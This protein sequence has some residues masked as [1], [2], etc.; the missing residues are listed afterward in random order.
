M[1]MIKTKNLNIGY[2]E[3][4]IVEELNIEIPKGRITALVGGNG[5][6]KSTI[7]KTIARIL[8]PQKGRVY[9]DGESIHEKS[10]KDVALKLAILPQNP[11][12]PE[13]LTVAELVSYGRFP[14]QKKFGTLGA[15]DYDIIQWALDVTGMT[16]FAERPLN[17]LSGG[18]RQK[19][20]IAMA[21]AQGTDVILL[22]EPTT[23]LD[24]SHQFEVLKLLRKLNKEHKQTIVMVVHDLNHATRFADYMIAIKG[25]KVVKEGNTIDIVTPE[26]IKEVF[27]IFADVI[28][29]G[30]MGVPHVIPY[31]ADE[32]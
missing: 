2:D 29:D 4:T 20:W 26:M 30:H 32:A 14:H 7:F 21:I 22:D 19:A 28:S 25:G 13:G 31:D 18:Q 9:L 11:T 6:G 1:S 10:T 16:V 24:M 27:G 5:S 8:K 3:K 15:E 17:S 12:A 23:F